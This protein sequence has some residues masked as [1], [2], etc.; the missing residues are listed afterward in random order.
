MEG[1]DLFVKIL[2]FVK[3]LSQVGLVSRQKEEKEEFQAPSLLKKRSKDPFLK[4]N[5]KKL[6]RG[7]STKVH[8]F[9]EAE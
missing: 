3:I 9:T 6:L 5:S 8:E 7:L 1:I 4:K 2:V